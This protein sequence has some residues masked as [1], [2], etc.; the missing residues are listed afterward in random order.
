MW[1]TFFLF[2]SAEKGKL[3]GKVGCVLVG[4]H[5]CTNRCCPGKDCQLANGKDE[6][7]P[8]KA[9]GG[10]W[11]NPEGCYYCYEAH[12]CTDACSP[13]HHQTDCAW[14]WALW[15]GVGGAGGVLCLTWQKRQ[16]Q[17]FILNSCC[18]ASC[19][20]VAWTT[21]CCQAAGWVWRE[22]AAR[23]KGDP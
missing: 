6:H 15:R 21:A 5:D 8:H 3:E 11:G 4:L 10:C 1:H 17:C 16:N 22:G 19:F 23:D 13:T 20:C 9:C 12:Y 14:H 7:E 18:Q 2:C